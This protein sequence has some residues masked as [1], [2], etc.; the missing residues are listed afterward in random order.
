M[1]NCIFQSQG[2]THWQSL[3]FQALPMSVSL[4]LQGC[5]YFKAQACQQDFSQ[6][7]MH[8]GTRL[9]HENIPSLLGQIH[10]TKDSMT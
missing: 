3:E 4:E 9:A 8:F 7:N 5:N 2:Y 6:L 10:G 1:D